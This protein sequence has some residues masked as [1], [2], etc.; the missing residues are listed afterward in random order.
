[1][2]VDRALEKLR[3]LLVKRGV[4]SNGCG[5]GR[6]DRGSSRGGCARRTGGRQSPVPALT[7]AAAASAASLGRLPTFRREPPLREYRRRAIVAAARAL[8]C[9]SKPTPRSAGIDALRQENPANCRAPGR[10]LNL[11]QTARRSG[12]AARG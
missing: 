3:A 4:T 9:S 6:R 5:A 2:R 11:K 1:M 12:D 7:G 10:N 8:P